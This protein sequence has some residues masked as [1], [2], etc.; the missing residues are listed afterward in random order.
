MRIVEAAGERLP[1][2]GA[3]PEEALAD[4]EPELAVAED[5]GQQLFV[6][7][8]VAVALLE[9]AVVSFSTMPVHCWRSNSTFTLGWTL[10][11][12]VTA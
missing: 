9:S 10:L 6:P 2:G 5:V 11:N 3:V 7:P 1:G 4:R 12:S 8:V